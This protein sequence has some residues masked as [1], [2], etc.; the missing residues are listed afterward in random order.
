MNI[1]CSVGE[2]PL[3]GWERKVGGLEDDHG[4]RLRVL[5]IGRGPMRVSDSPTYD[6]VLVTYNSADC[7]G[8][9]LAAT[10]AFF[11]RR[12]CRVILV[13]NASSDDSVAIARA[14]LPGVIV[15]QND[16]NVGFATAVNQAFS[17]ARSEWVLLVNPDI[18]RIDGQVEVLESVAADRSVAAVGVRMVDSCNV[19]RRSCHEAPTPFTMLSES[20]ALHG[21]FPRWARVGRYRMLGWDMTTARDVEDACGG[22]LALRRSAI[23]DVGPFDERFFLYYEETDWLLRAREAGWRVAFTPEL[24]V[25]HASG[26]STEESGD[27]LSLHLLRSQYQYLR[28]HFGVGWELAMRT[29]FACLDVG[30]WLL[31]WAGSERRETARQ[32]ARRLR[33]HIGL[34]SQRG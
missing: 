16:Q 33:V 23:E 26:G 24:Q 1:R 32:A 8:E 11:E 31:G 13:D 20:L 28:K 3:G 9:C 30:R 27:T 5:S 29:V 17:V 21:R 14:V 15:I 10:A 6:V 22:F 4:V 18:G 7:V 25:V 12:N 19:L 34:R 2:P